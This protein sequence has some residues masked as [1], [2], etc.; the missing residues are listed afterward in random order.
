[1]SAAKRG[2][3]AVDP[4]AADA[5]DTQRRDEILDTASSVF[6]S[7]GLRTT[8]Q[9]IAEASG[10]QPGSLYHHFESKEAIVIELVKRYHA[11]LDRQADVA[12]KELRESAPGD[13]P[14][15]ITAFSTAI[16]EC[17]ARHSAAVQFSFY[18]P[19]VSAGH[20]LVLLV[21]RAPTA[22]ERA[23][24][25]TLEV[26]HA[27]GFL[28]D[29]IDLG[30][31]SHRLTQT[32]LHVGLGLYHRYRS[33]DRVADHLCSMVLFGVATRAPRD[34]LLDGSKAM[35]AVEEVMRSWDDGSVSEVSDRSA[36]IKAVART[37]F[38]RR[39]YEATTVRDIAGAAQMS[40]GSVYREIGSKEELLVSIMR[41]F[42]EKVVAGW[43]AALTS[44]STSVEKL[45]AVAWLQI[46]VL[47]RFH[48]EFKIQLAWLRQSPPD[49][50]DMAWS[51]PGLLQ[52]LK[53]M[54]RDGAR[55]GEL[56]IEG[57]S[58]ELTARSIVDL[59]WVPEGI[60]RTYGRRTALVHVRDTMLRGAAKRG[61]TSKALRS[62]S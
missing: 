29:D 57:P 56:K 51:F 18:D 58:T 61:A 53:V 16:A 22:T 20:E 21:A 32:M 23:M 41:S 44:T 49:T 60:L 27:A 24:L 54:L 39:G 15:R 1:M 4:D 13:L 6:A 5:L 11:D 8:L 7:S 17:A 37:E 48:D 47:E 26:G 33:V 3:H 30:M 50:P 2:P 19:P 14:A 25:K 28:R 35:R 43:D 55:A 9:E 12:L 42:S 45:D 10:I 46:N 31:L 34:S 59:T 62:H 40:T 52:R 36:L 38:G